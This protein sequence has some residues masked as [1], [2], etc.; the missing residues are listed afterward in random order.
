MKTLMIAPAVVLAL[1]TAPASASD[2]YFGG[3]TGY[4]KSSGSYDSK[5]TDGDR[6]HYDPSNLDLSGAVNSVFIGTRGYNISD[7]TSIGAEL[8]FT[9]FGGG[10]TKDITNGFNTAT[11]SMNNSVDA[12]LMVFHDLSEKTTVFVGAGVS[13]GSFNWGYSLNDWSYKP[14][15]RRNLRGGRSYSSA[16]VVVQAG[17]EHEIS[18]KVS[19]RASVTHRRYGKRAHGSVDLSDQHFGYTYTGDYGSASS[20]TAVMVGL[21]FKF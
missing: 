9:S 11:L 3:S 15:T 16:G 19:I 8:E 2:F 12:K 6:T 17:V 5:Y 14:N 13:Y 7:K 1:I 21:V 20:S 4:T 10:A 18:K